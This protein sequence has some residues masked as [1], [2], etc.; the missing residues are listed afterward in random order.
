M[1]INLKAAPFEAVDLHDAAKEAEREVA[2]R[3]GAYAKWVDA[4]RMKPETA[5][6][7]YTHMRKAASVLKW[8]AGN[9]DK[10]KTALRIAS[11]VDE[12]SADIKLGLEFVKLFRGKPELLS[13]VLD[14]T[15]L[16]MLAKKFPGAKIISMSKLEDAA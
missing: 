4:G 9:M 2:I 7:Q 16:D 8:V 10:I 5:V 13:K 11:W 3:E 15:A 14:S 6:A 1:T 12:R